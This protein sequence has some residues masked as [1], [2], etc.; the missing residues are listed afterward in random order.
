MILIFDVPCSANYRAH[1]CSF[2]LCRPFE[3]CCGVVGLSGRHQPHCARRRHHDRDGRSDRSGRDILELWSLGRLRRCPG[4]ERVIHAWPAVRSAHSKYSA[5]PNSSRDHPSRPHPVRAIW[6]RRDIDRVFF[7]PAQGA[8]GERGGDFRN[9][10][11]EIRSGEYRII[12]DLDAIRGWNW[13]NPR[14]HDRAERLLVANRSGPCAGRYRR[15]FRRDHVFARATR[16]GA[17]VA[18]MARQLH[19]FSLTALPPRRISARPWPQ[20][21]PLGMRKCIHE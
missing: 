20:E 17:V 12:P 10:A 7:R 16:P 5:A 6:F 13:R 19:V 8:D 1:S 2:F 15:N 11:R 9:E 3:L 21:R 14:N 18:G 4:Y